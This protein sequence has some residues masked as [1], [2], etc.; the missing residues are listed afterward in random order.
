MTATVF[1]HAGLPKTGTTYLQDTLWANRE[2]LETQGVLLPGRDR[3]R[4]LLASLDIRDDPK[5]ANRAG[6]VEAPWQ[7]LVDDTMA[8]AGPTAI[9]SH[10]FFGAASAKQVARAVASLEGCEVHLVLTARELVGLGT[11]YWQ[12][13]VKN[14]GAGD[15]DGFPVSPRYS[16]VDEWGWGAFDLAGVLERWGT[17]IPPERVHIF[18]VAVGK[19]DPAELWQRFADLVGIE[20]EGLELKESPSNPGLGIVEVELLRRINARLVGFESA[21]SRG[22][23]IRGHLAM[24]QVLPRSR[25]SFRAGDALVEELVSRGNR[26][27]EAL[28]AGG[29]DVRGDL[30]LLRPVRPSADLRH[31]GQVTDS[32]LVDAAA[33]S[34]ANLMTQVRTLTRER[35]DARREL[36]LTQNRR[37]S[38][39]VD[40]L[41][42][43][44]RGGES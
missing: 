1:L 21:G 2:K 24:G 41:R 16:P 5:L 33:Q 6:D 43:K 17:V 11:S 35:N 19:A 36:S 3:R 7:E 14:G 8:W 44:S 20:T 10:E 25:E 29:Y 13:W 30:D 26:A 40:R 37:K 32:E 9:I 39:V 34:I 4:H 18:P 31:P 23:W 12:E 28:R 15:V 22:R 27:L 42:R 38:R